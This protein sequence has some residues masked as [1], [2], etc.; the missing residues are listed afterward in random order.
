MNAS[1]KMIAAAVVG[2]G[3]LGAVNVVNAQTYTPG[4]APPAYPAYT[5]GPP[6]QAAPIPQQAPQLTDQQLDQ[7]TG[8]IALYPDPLLAQLLPAATFPDDVTAAA[9]YLA[10]YPQPSE[11]AINAQPWD[12]SVKAIVHYPTVLKQMSDNIE[13]T[14]ALGA[15]FINQQQDVMESIQRLRA[16]AQNAG[17]LAT[18]P[19]QQVVA[20]DGGIQ[21]L[22]ANPQVIYVPTYDPQVVYVRRVPLVFSPGFHVGVWLNN[23]FDWRRHWVTRGFDWS[24]GWRDHRSPVVIHPWVRDN[25]RPAPVLPP[26]WAPRVA[27]PVRPGWDGHRDAPSAFGGWKDRREYDHAL[28]RGRQSLPSRPPVIRTAPPVNRAPV[29]PP[30]VVAPVRP[31]VSVQAPGGRV[32]VRPGGVSV[33]TPGA[34]ARVNSDRGHRSMGR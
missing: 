24:R 12:P 27:A 34:D 31:G 2:A 33:F 23:G 18:T 1:L 10:A 3:F 19:Q 17:T 8:P 21:I 26:K 7:L 25:R 16:Q 28:E 11:D 6:V 20:D 22:P 4:Y 5:P 15:A 14:Q 32:N 29:A 13:W 9:Q 30:Q